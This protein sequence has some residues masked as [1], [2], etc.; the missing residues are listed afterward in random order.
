MS[1]LAMLFGNMPTLSFGLGSDVG[2]ILN[3]LVRERPARMFAN[4]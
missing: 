1:E 2:Q 3:A 4:D